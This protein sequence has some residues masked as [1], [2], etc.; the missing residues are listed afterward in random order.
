MSPTTLADVVLAVHVAFVAFVVGGFALILAG[1]A[2]GWA[3]VRNPAFRWAH[4]GA[5]GF[6]ALEALAGI[7]CPLTVWEDLL[8]RGTPG[9]ASFVGRWLAR[10]LYWDLP[11]WVFTVTY[12]AFAA[13]VAFV[14]WRHPP[15]RPRGRDG[16]SSGGNM[17]RPPQHP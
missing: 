10:L 1:I 11:P 13:A 4:L 17:D 8:R 6:V 12:V 16:L 2:R 9:E 3:W 5:I 15:R 14:L 7:A